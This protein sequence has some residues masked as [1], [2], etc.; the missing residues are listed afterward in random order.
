MTE[1][2]ADE[3]HR[4]AKLESTGALKTLLQ[5]PDLG[6]TRPLLD[7]DIRNAIDSLKASTAAIQKQTE[8]LTLQ[9]EDLK[10]QLRNDK[11]SE[12]GRSRALDQLKRRHELERQHIN[13]AVLS[14]SRFTLG[15][16]LLTGYRLM[17]LR[18]ILRRE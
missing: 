12:L 8:I 7:E 16:A 17:I 18:M 14:P 10:R 3:H 15:P 11:E 9:C 4:Y 5:N 13:A 2:P 1:I 6:A